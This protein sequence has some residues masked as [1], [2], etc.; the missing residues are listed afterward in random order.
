M[1]LG[2]RLEA[3]DK[4]SLQ[5]SLDRTAKDLRDNQESD[6]VIEA[7]RRL[8]L[9]DTNGIY[10]QITVSTTGVLTTTNVGATLP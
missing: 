7:P 8:F 5:A 10:W 2:A 4:R 6:V 9:R 1:A 3:R